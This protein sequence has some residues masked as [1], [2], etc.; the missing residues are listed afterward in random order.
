MFVTKLKN[1][2]HVYQTCT[3]Y[4]IP[5][6]NFLFLF[7]LIFNST[8]VWEAFCVIAKSEALITLL[9][10]GSMSGGRERKCLNLANES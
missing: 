10:A 5:V 7:C 8:L 3:F 1:V 2:N 4:K 9:L 6:R